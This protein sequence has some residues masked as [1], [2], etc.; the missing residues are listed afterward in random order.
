MA[1]GMGMS[2]LVT[3]VGSVVA[4]QLS[5]W[6]LPELTA[7]YPV[8]W[9]VAAAAAAWLSA[10]AAPVLGGCTALSAYL[11]CGANTE[12][13]RAG[14]ARMATSLALSASVWLAATGTAVLVL[15]TDFLSTA[16][17]SM[18]MAGLAL[19]LPLAAAIALWPLAV[20]PLEEAPSRKD[21]AEGKAASTCGMLWGVT[22]TASVVAVVVAV[23]LTLQVALV[24][25]SGSSGPGLERALEIAQPM[26]EHA[27]R[28]VGSVMGNRGVEL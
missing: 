10:V 5:G 16:Q 15:G 3:Y 8:D 18:L 1:Y 17:D 2:A 4:L 24:H 7:V 11:C 14:K 25:L 12:A 21:T 28:V 22:A 26:L 19:G 20:F 9:L 27:K 6:P 23:L 13:S